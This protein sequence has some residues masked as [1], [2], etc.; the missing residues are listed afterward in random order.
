MNK[1]SPAEMEEFKITKTIRTVVRLKHS[2]AADEEIN[3]VLPDTINS[4]REG[5]QRGELLQL[6]GVIEG[7]IDGVNSKA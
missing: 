3:D 4:F 5:L 1:K 2:L 7:I 6:E